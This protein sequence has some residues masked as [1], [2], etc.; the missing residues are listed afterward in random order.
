[1]KLRAAPLPPE[2]AKVEENAAPRCT[3]RA[4]AMRR[5]VQALRA[6]VPEFRSRKALASPLPSYPSH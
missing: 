4:D 1:M 6:Q 5:L 2:W 3:V